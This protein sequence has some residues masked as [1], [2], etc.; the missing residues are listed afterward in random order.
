[1][2]VAVVVG[3]LGG[4]LAGWGAR[5]LLGRLRRGVSIRPPVLELCA[6]AVTGVGVA[7]SWPT[8]LLGL[9]VWAG[10]LAVTLGAVDIAAHR[11]P[12]ALTRPALPITAALVGVTW[13]L[14][15]GSGHP[16][17]ALTA[18]V[19]VTG[20]FWAMAALAPRAMGR[21]DVKLVPSLALMAGY[22]SAAAVLWWLMIAF[23]LGALVALVGLAARRLSMESAI[24]F[25]PWLLVG[26]WA[27]L[28]IPELTTR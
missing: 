25:G 28:A 5:Q 11:L 12:D 22:L 6:A 4:A 20:I 1:M 17:T 3:T 24:P 27:V 16:V 14:E 7:L 19:L 18:A 23:V 10:L 21:G 13:M 2:L 9:V 15:P 26:C 8:P